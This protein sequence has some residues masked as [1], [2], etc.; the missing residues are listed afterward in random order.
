MSTK[1]SEHFTEAELNCHCGCGK[2]VDPN[3]L[4][5]LEE[6]RVILGKPIVVNSG[7]R[8]EEYNRKEGG[9]PGSM[10]LKGLAVDIHCN[11]SA[12]RHELIGIAYELEF[13]GI[14]IAK[15]FTHLDLR[16]VPSVCFLY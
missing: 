4:Q 6:M 16:P 14:G 11:D 8:C 13:T 3:L 5:K 15:T 10:H 7:A 12:F 2:T 1:I 9:K